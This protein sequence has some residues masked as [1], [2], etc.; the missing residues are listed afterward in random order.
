MILWKR[1]SVILSSEIVLSLL[2]AYLATAYSFRYPMLETWQ[3]YTGWSEMS[4]AS[5]SLLLS[6]YT[7]ILITRLLHRRTGANNRV[8]ERLF[9]LALFVLLTAVAAMYFGTDFWENAAQKLTPATPLIGCFA[10]L[11]AGM[12]F[13]NLAMGF[14][15]LL[16]GLHFSRVV[17]RVYDWRG[18]VVRVNLKQLSELARIEERSAYTTTVELVTPYPEC[19]EIEGKVISGPL[20]GIRGPASFEIIGSGHAAILLSASKEGNDIV[21][22]LRYIYHSLRTHRISE[23]L[24]LNLLAPRLYLAAAYAIYN[25]NEFCSLHE[26]EKSND[27]LSHMASC[28]TGLRKDCVGHVQFLVRQKRYDSIASRLIENLQYSMT[29]DP[30]T[31]RS[32]KASK[33]LT[34]VNE[35]VRKTTGPTYAVA[36]NVLAW[37]PTRQSAETTIEAICQSIALQGMFGFIMTKRVNAF[38]MCR[39]VQ[40]HEPYRELPMTNHDLANLIHMP[41]HPCRGMRIIRSSPK[42]AGSLP[43][44]GEDSLSSGWEL[45]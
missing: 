40:A 16:S 14:A 30:Q 28:L 44:E 45:P 34:L 5:T 2:L 38:D 33:Q 6:V 9:R 10:N 15:G 3:D 20:S 23:P 7:L 22:A 29:T 35:I 36:I 39:H 4:I 32:Y 19:S 21:S 27:T 11:A 25:D 8:E 18:I 17:S 43:P 1:Y 26:F 37:S 24:P 41:V 42:P 13:I 31:L 12:G